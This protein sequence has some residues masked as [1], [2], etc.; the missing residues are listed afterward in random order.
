MSDWTD[1][2]WDEY[3]REVNLNY[4]AEVEEIEMGIHP[5]QLEMENELW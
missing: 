5:S 2:E 4:W 3:I 1:E